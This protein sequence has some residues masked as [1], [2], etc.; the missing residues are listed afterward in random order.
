MGGTLG[1]NDVRTM[2]SEVVRSLGEGHRTWEM[3]CRAWLRGG[4]TV[5]CDT[6]MG[7]T[8]HLSDLNGTFQPRDANVAH[9]FK[10]II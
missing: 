4:G 8:M 9:L 7:A 3:A 10:K 6:S 5:P 2:G 1:S